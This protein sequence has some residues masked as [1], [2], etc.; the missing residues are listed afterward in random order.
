MVTLDLMLNDDDV[1]E[2]GGYGVLSESELM[3]VAAYLSQQVP[4][5]RDQSGFDL[6]WIIPKLL[7]AKKTGSGG[8]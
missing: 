4:N 1:R 6:C 8:R 3:E 2:L 5:W 7:P